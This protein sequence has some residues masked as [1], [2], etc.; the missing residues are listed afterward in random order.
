MTGYLIWVAFDA[1]TWGGVEDA[2][3]HVADELERHGIQIAWRIEDHDEYDA[4][5]TPDPFADDEEP[6]R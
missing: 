2:T 5:A 1:E 4:D 6:P 3:N